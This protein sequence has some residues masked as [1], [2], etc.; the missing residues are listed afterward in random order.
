MFLGKPRFET[1]PTIYTIKKKNDT[2]AWLQCALLLTGL[3]RSRFYETAFTVRLMYHPLEDIL[4]K[5]I[6]YLEMK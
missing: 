2:L 6:A 5:I 3:I 4:H 1:L